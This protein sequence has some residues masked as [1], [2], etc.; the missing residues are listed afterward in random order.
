MAL[1]IPPTRVPNKTASAAEWKSWHESLKSSFGQKNAN[2]LFLAAWKK[3]GGVNSAANT[4]DLRTYL[5]DNGI[6]LDKN[7]VGSIADG[8]ASVTDV[9]GDLFQIQKYI[10][11]AIAVVVIGG[12]GMLIYNLAKNP[13]ASLGAVAKLKG[14]K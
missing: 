8:A 11:I 13:V 4:S 3:R 10:G 2:M 12:A 14:G 6:S 5:E 7:W 1:K 9:F